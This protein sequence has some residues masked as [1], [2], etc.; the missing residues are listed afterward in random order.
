MAE[1]FGTYQG[2]ILKQCEEII[3]RG[4][5]RVSMEATMKIC[6][7]FS[8]KN[9]FLLDC[10]TEEGLR[11]HSF[12]FIPIP[13]NAHWTLLSL[14]LRTK[15]FSHYNSLEGCPNYKEVGVMVRTVYS[16]YY[17][18]CFFTVAAQCMPLTDYTFLLTINRRPLWRIG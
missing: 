5:S 6:D 14:N 1:F 11:Q 15:E 16:T 13:A 4:A 17:S 7:R 10:L 9:K 2:Y 3:R 18:S 8:A 12:L